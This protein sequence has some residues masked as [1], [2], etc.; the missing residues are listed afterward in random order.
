MR[1]VWS[2]AFFALIFIALG[3]IFAW[4]TTRVETGWSPDR[5]VVDSSALRR[6]EEAIAQESKLFTPEWMQE[7]AKPQEA[8]RLPAEEGAISW[9]LVD[10]KFRINVSL[11]LRFDNPDRFQKRCLDYFFESRKIASKAQEGE[12]YDIRLPIKDPLAAEELIKELATYDLKATLL[13]IEE[14]KPY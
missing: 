12:F 14:P 1:G 6:E 3:A 11:I 10:P 8:L 9:D 2:V 4:R 13:T 5:I 7:M